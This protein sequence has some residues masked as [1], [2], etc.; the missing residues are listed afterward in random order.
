MLLVTI[1]TREQI[2]I[3][4]LSA[5]ILALEVLVFAEQNLGLLARGSSGNSQDPRL[6]SA[7]IFFEN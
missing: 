7:R 2:F 1:S 3:I 5:V 6:R 4:L